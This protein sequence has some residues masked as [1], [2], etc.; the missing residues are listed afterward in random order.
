MIR[1]LNPK[2]FLNG[3]LSQM[4]WYCHFV[5]YCVFLMAQMVK[6][7][8][9]M[10]EIRV[11]SPV[12]EDPTASKVFFLS[13]FLFLF[14][15]SFFLSFFFLRF[16]YPKPHEKALLNVTNKKGLGAV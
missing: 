12:Q 7:L 13:F 1:P 15:F 8:P 6:H 3:F 14:F 4:F 5:S 11:R 2:V 10:W 16:L 9:A